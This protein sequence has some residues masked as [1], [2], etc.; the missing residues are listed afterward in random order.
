MPIFRGFASSKIG[1]GGL[2]LFWKDVW[3]E[4]TT[5]AAFPRAFSC[6]TNEDIY[7]KEFLIAPRLSD[8]F[9]LPLS[10]QAMDELRDLQAKT[11]TELTSNSDVWSYPW[12][13][14]YTSSQYYQFCFK[15]LQPHISTIWLWKSKCT[16]RV[17]FFG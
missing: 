11:A 3:L 8:N 12:S 1:D 17:K 7:V 13:P 4:E 16:P 14:A 6:A 9:L 15:D 5:E 10:P 2:T